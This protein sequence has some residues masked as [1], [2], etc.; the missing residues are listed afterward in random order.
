MPIT[1]QYVSLDGVV[2][3]LKTQCGLYSSQE[4][5]SLIKNCHI[6][7]ENYSSRLLN[8]EGAYVLLYVRSLCL[9]C[10][11]SFIQRVQIST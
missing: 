2:Y 10:R 4:L 8:V 7:K 3:I 6:K 5:K 1:A 9:K 11:G